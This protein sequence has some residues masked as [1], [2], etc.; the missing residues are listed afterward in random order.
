[1]KELHLG[2]TLSMFV[3]VIMLGGM[4]SEMGICFVLNI[5]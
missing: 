2:N 5:V 4:H 3:E 1:M